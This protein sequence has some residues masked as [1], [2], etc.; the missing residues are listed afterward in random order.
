MDQR[1]WNYRDMDWNG[2]WRAHHDHKNKKEWSTT[3]HWDKRAKEFTRAVTRGD[4]VEQFLELCDVRPE[5]SVLD[6]GAAAGTLAAPLAGRATSVTAL[7]PSIMMRE[8]LR[9]RCASEGIRNLRAVEGRWED[10]W[11]ALGIA[12]HDVAIASRSLI[13]EDLS[14]AIDKLQAY[15]SRRAYLSTL[16]DDGPFDRNLITAVGRE[17][18]PGVDYIVVLNYLRQIG[19]YAN[20][21]FTTHREARQFASLDE[22]VTG[23]SWMVHDITDAEQNKLREYLD[24]TLVHVDG[25][26]R[27]PRPRPVRWAVMWWDKEDTCAAN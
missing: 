20:L 2:I 27:L 19:I 1:E 14:L 10:D 26:L 23:L 21:T 12:P 18:T 15:A 22:A 5:E 6:I 24:A 16:V 7:E 4:Y 11:D 17:F 8:L 3:N 9:K 13:V 25:M